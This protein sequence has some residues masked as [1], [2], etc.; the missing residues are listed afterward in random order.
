MNAIRTRPLRPGRAVLAAAAVAAWIVAAGAAFAQEPASPA[1]EP[2]RVVSDA[3]GQ[4]LQV[5]GREW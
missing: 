1:V 5:G 3:A 2:V 4:R